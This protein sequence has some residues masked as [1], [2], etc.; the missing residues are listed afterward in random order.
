MQTSNCFCIKKHLEKFTGKVGKVKVQQFCHFIE[1]IKIKHMHGS[2]HMRAE[3]Q[4]SSDA[5]KASKVPAILFKNYGYCLT[6]FLSV[7]SRW[8]TAF[9][10]LKSKIKIPDHKNQ[11]IYLF[12]SSSNYIKKFRLRLLLENCRLIGSKWFRGGEILWNKNIYI[13]VG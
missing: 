9:Y 10:R 2:C 8:L 4:F 5:N 6:Y 7:M 1:K 11:T 13:S 12:Y 3:K